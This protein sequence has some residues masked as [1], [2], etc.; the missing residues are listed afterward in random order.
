MKRE[1]KQKTKYQYGGQSFPSVSAQKAG[2]ELAR[3]EAKHGGLKPSIVVQESR[4]ETAVL[5]P[6]FEWDDQVAAEKYRNVQAGQ[7]IRSVR[8][9][10]ESPSGVK[11]RTPAYVSVV[12]VVDEDM[13]H[14]EYV[15]TSRAMEN[16]EWRRG[17]MSEA[18]DQL[19]GF[20]RRYKQL[21]DLAGLTEEVEA[22]I[23]RYTS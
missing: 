18:L 15:S 13:A 23:E 1:K 20:A 8:V 22:I 14:R 17:V 21:G 7:I 16:D 2:D 10:H 11:E 9:V 19:R 5:H 4:P 12:R 3:I 6:V